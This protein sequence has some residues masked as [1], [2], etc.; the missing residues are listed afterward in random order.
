M[1]DYCFAELDDCVRE[2]SLILP[3]FPEVI[4]ERNSDNTTQ[5]E[6]HTNIECRDTRTSKETRTSEQTKESE[7]N[8]DPGYI[9][10]V[11][12]SFEFCAL[13]GVEV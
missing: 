7:S 13:R 1:Q 8:S 6:N 5:D 12:D 2:S 9:P 11:G 10:V 4:D 3:P